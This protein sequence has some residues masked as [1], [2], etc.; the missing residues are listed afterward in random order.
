M[1]DLEEK[2]GFEEADEHEL[3]ID[4]S[5]KGEEQEKATE[6]KPPLENVLG[7]ITRLLSVLTNSVA[8]I[9]VNML[10]K[11]DISGL[12]D[13]NKVHKLQQTLKN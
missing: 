1:N 3:S 7:D 6:L 13:V 11:S 4:D 12:E 9:S 10:L 5:T 2:E 8:T